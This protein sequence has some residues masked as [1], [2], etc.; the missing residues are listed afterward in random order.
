[1]SKGQWKEVEWERGRA[2]RHY[3]TARAVALGQDGCG[4]AAVQRAACRGAEAGE[5]MMPWPREVAVEVLRGQT[6]NVL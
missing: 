5:R 6:L 4:L 1:M 2:D 3:R